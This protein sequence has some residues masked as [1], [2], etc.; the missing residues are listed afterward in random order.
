MMVGFRSINVEPWTFAFPGLFTARNAK[1]GTTSTVNTLE[2]I[3][4][5]EELLDL[6]QSM[7]IAFS[8]LG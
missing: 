1:F 2:A 4:S 6:P 5:A 7:I 3:P 8:E